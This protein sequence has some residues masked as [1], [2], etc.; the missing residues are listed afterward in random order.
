MPEMRFMGEMAIHPCRVGME[1]S[2]IWE[3]RVR[4]HPP[5]APDRRMI[6]PQVACDGVLTGP[7]PAYGFRRRGRGSRRAAYGFGRPAPGGAGSIA[8]SR[9]VAL[10]AAF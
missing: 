10:H 4:S 6:G 9:R 8:T 2:L 3:P 7:R 5:V 1:C